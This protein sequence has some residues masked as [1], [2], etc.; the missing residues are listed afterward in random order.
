MDDPKING[1]LREALIYA[2]NQEERLKVFLDDGNIPIDNGYVE[3]CIKP[4]ALSRRN[5][6]FSYSMAGAEA[7]VIMY[8]IVETAK[9]NGADVYT[10]L[11]YIL[12]ETRKI[13]G[14]NDMRIME[15]LMPWSPEYRS[16]E[17]A[18]ME[19]H[20]DETKPESNECPEGVSSKSQYT[21]VA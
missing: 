17:K 2:I 19:S 3:R 14:D 20:S 16:F 1:K 8:T 6:L 13:R 18:D 11:K 7:N 9:A 10:Y 5:S 4:I 15:K 12:M 21:K